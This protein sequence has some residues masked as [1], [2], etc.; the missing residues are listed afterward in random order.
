MLLTQK[1]KTKEASFH[2][3]QMS[4]LPKAKERNPGIVVLG[5]PAHHT[6]RSEYNRGRQLGDKR[7]LERGFPLKSFRDL[8]TM[9]NQLEVQVFPAF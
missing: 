6:V 1:S 2:F 9:G 4:L 8:R 7:S 5:W 3:R